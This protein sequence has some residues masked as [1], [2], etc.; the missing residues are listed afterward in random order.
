M[1]S[2]GADTTL[3][4]VWQ[5]DLLHEWHPLPTDPSAMDRYD[6]TINPPGQTQR[7]R[8]D[9][10]CRHPQGNR[11]VQALRVP[12]QRRHGEGC[13]VVA[14]VVMLPH[15]SLPLAAH[16]KKDLEGA[17]GLYDTKMS[18]ADDRGGSWRWCKF[19]GTNTAERAAAGQVL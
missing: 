5:E 14:H 19:A 18:Q 12:R 4:P 15:N 17:L 16:F 6:P 1:V 3:W 9:H 13:S 7:E 10:L 11:W 2:A 8:G